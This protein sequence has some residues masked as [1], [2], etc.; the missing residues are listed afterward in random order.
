MIKIIIITKGVE[1]IMIE[2][3]LFLVL[4]GMIYLIYTIIFSILPEI[5]KLNNKVDVLVLQAKETEYNLVRNK[6]KIVE[7]HLN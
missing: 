5:K 4:L 6:E 2:T 3:Y 1:K 7:K